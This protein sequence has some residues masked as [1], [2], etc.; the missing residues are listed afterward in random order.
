MGRWT[1]T[2]SI[3][4]LRTLALLHPRNAFPPAP[5]TQVSYSYGA[6]VR[7]EKFF[8]EHLNLAFSRHAIGVAALLSSIFG[9][10]TRYLD[11]I[12][13]ELTAAGNDAGV[14]AVPPEPP[15]VLI[16]PVGVIVPGVDGWVLPAPTPGPDA[17]KVVVEE[18]TPTPTSDDE[19]NA[20]EPEPAANTE[21][22]ENVVVPKVR[23][24]LFSEACDGKLEDL[25]KLREVPEGYPVVDVMAFGATG[26]GE[27]DDS[28]AIQDAIDSAHGDKTSHVQLYFPPG[29]YLVTRKFTLGLPTNGLQSFTVMGAGAA[30][31]RIVLKDDV[32]LFSDRDS[33]VGVFAGHSS[34]SSKVNFRDLA[35]NIGSDNPGAIGIDWQTA[36][37]AE[38][39]RVLVEGPALAGLR[40]RNGR[41]RAYVQGL[42]V[43]GART[44]LI[45]QDAIPVTIDGL[46]ARDFADV[47]VDNDG[48]LFA[49]CIQT[50]T[51]KDAPALE[52][53]PQA[54]ASIA[55]ARLSRDDDSVPSAM[56][57]PLASLHLRDVILE[58]YDRIDNFEEAE[59]HGF[60]GTKPAALFNNSRISS[61]RLPTAVSPEAPDLG[62]SPRVVK[63]LRANADSTDLLR[64]AFES[65]NAEIILAPGTYAVSRPI[66]IPGTVAR[67][68]APGAKIRLVDG[69][70]FKQ[71]ARSVLTAGS[72]TD[73]PLVIEDLTIEASGTAHSNT[74]YFDHSGPRSV[75]LRR[76][77]FPNYS[78]TE[79]GK[80][81]SLFVENASIRT[82]NVLAKQ[83]A[84]LR[85]PHWDRS[86]DADG[87]LDNR[88]TTWTLG[89]SV[90]A[91]N[92]QLYTL[93]GGQ[94]ELLGGYV[95]PS[96]VPADG[97]GRG[98]PFRV[99]NARGTLSFVAE[100]DKN[101]QLL[102]IRTKFTRLL[103][104]G[105]LPLRNKGLSIS[106]ATLVSAAA[107]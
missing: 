99:E 27:S 88:G 78:P 62:S 51:S 20:E 106:H 15:I 102:E 34:L 75:T 33:P 67:I 86:G 23:D 28:D 31:S 43:T 39:R 6:Y 5:R 104:L 7:S 42:E 18:A 76:V 48:Q 38:V 64:D 37:G 45:I 44:S 103:Q 71:S 2:S 56:R 21:P 3:E 29:R 22:P 17:E 101:R 40:I 25:T 54:F 58:G 53:H 49:H 60:L 93:S 47:G 79:Q 63:P 11:P 35:V 65:G 61:L 81:G 55:G 16:P 80:V 107:E 69:H 19:P 59:I 14:G 77:E 97:G 72:E 12:A 41:P 105:E 36:T 26:D 90:G 24:D 13:Q 89:A 66:S 83:S 87:G 4:I 50:E 10:E 1:V 91:K 92:V 32:D 98:A 94:F 84:W 95:G 73:T 100:G 96:G 70:R 68:M 82:L 74:R 46:V 8:M 9:C 85:A 30:H 52:I 57:G